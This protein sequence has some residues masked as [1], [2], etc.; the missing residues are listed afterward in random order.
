[1]YIPE[2]IWAGVASLDLWA[3]VEKYVGRTSFCYLYTYHSHI[4]TWCPN[5]F[6][7]PRFELLIYAISNFEL[8]KFPQ[9]V[10]SKDDLDRPHHFPI[11][12]V[13]FILCW[14]SFI[15]P[16]CGRSYRAVRR[17][18]F[19]LC[20]FAVFLMLLSL[21]SVLGNLDGQRA[22]SLLLQGDHGTIAPNTRQ[23]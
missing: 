10:Y 19:S 18:M 23:K 7:T 13:R 12:I 22:H 3:L 15:F 4:H 2:K 9:N 16:F 1:M 8:S 21:G 20:G 11:S 5:I 17:P 14:D 6:M